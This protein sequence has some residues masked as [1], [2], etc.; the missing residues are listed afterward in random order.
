M[1]ILASILDPSDNG[2]DIG[3]LSVLIGI[4]VSIS[5]LTAGIVRWNAKRVAADRAH[6]RQRMERRLLDEIEARTK[7]IQPYANG[8]KSLPDLHTKVDVLIERQADIAKR[9]DNHI[10]WHLD[11]E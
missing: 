7:P 4:I 3:D 6:E 5:L 11:K 8:G 1:H 2:F 9:L 10:T